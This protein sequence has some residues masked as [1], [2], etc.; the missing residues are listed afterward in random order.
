[1]YCTVPI[2][3][4]DYTFC[5]YTFC[6]YTFCEYTFCEYTFCEYTFCEYTFFEYALRFVEHMFRDNITLREYTFYFAKNIFCL[7]KIDLR[8]ILIYNTKINSPYQSV[9]N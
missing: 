8:L 1:M 4:C 9:W 6:E 2:Q 7:G 5:E 3:F